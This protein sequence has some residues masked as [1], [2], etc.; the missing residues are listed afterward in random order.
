MGTA[1]KVDDLDMAESAEVEFNFTD[2]LGV[3]TITDA[4][5]T[6]DLRE[7]QDPTPATLLSGVR[8]L[9]V[10]GKKVTQMLHGRMP[11]CSYAVRCVAA[12]SDGLDR[13]A[14]ALIKVVRL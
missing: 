3:A 4:V 14:V 13:T 7:G 12:C 6:V 1:K 5:V 10:G 8:V 11:K 9:V 2:E